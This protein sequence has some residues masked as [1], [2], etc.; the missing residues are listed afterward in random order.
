MQRFGLLG[1]SLKHSY[2]PIIH[3]GFG[4][5][6]YKLYEKRPEE[7]DLFFTQGEFDGLNVTI[8]HKTAVLKYCSSMSEAARTIGSVNTIIK[9]NDGTYYGDNTDYFGFLYLLKKTGIDIKGEKVLI[10]GSGGSSLTVRAVLKDEGAGQITVISRNGTDNYN[11]IRSHS[12]TVM[13]VN[14]TPVGMYPHNGVSPIED[15]SCFKKCKIV[16]DLIY[17]PCI[18]QLMFQAESCGI[19]SVSGLSMLVAQAKRSAEHFLRSDIHDAKIEELTAKINEQTQ[20]IILI[21]MPGCGKSTTGKLLAKKMNKKFADTDSIIE[22]KTGKT[23]AE[24]I[25]K[26]GE[27]AFRKLETEALKE[28]CKQSSIIIATG[29][30]AVTRPENLNIM[31]QNGKIVYLER[32]ISQLPTAGRPL[33]EKDGLE[34]LAAKRIPLYE[35]WSDI[36]IE[37]ITPEKA[38]KEIIK[39]A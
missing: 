7:L 25:T 32:E 21:G 39:Q 10:L 8:P 27:E 13:I 36:T 18:T 14:T 34:N 12:D 29:G 19:P 6:E 16:I 17:N 38:A 37:S 31:R 23:A 22:E 35:K 1:E 26:D 15:L 20:N 3:A 28:L 30:G 9:Q 24:I 5:Y 33:S 2:S 4:D 11:N